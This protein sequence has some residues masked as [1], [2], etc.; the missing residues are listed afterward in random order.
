MVLHLEHGITN[1]VER[2]NTT[3]LSTHH[4]N[5]ST[6][7]LNPA[8]LVC[9]AAVEYKPVRFRP[10]DDSGPFTAFAGWMRGVPVRACSTA[11]SPCS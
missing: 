10:V 8:S 5:Q 7:A 2:S 11:T 9:P 1:F 6:M 3:I 4:N